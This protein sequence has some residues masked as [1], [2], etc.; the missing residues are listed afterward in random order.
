MQRNVSLIICQYH[1]AECLQ[2][3]LWGCCTQTYRNFEVVVVVPELHLSAVTAV[4]EKFRKLA[5]F[6]ITL[7]SSPLELPMKALIA[8]VHTDYLVFTSATAVPRQDFLAKHLQYRELGFWLQG[9]IDFISQS[10]Y[11]SLSQ[12]AIFSG[13]AFENKWLKTVETRISTWNDPLYN[14][15]WKAALYNL[16]SLSKPVLNIKNASFWKADLRYLESENALDLQ[17]HVKGL[18]KLDVRNFAYRTTAL[19]PKTTDL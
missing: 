15:G 5:F 12:D 10:S 14:W 13:K 3:V 1:S 18:K 6:P 4:V 9:R 7:L 2:K 8:A 11:D 19:S 17:N 16:L